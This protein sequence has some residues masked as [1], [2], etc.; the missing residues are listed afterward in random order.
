[1]PLSF[2]EVVARSVGLSL[3]EVG[4]F[5][6]EELKEWYKKTCQNVAEAD[7]NDDE[8]GNKSVHYNPFDYAVM[9]SEWKQL[10]QEVL[11]WYRL[12]SAPRR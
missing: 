8:C 10:N 6:L 2:L 3:D 5:S 4:R 1:M 12:R 7:L 11:P 9:V